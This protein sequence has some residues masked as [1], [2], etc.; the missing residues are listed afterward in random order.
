MNTPVMWPNTEACTRFFSRSLSKISWRILGH[1]VTRWASSTSATSG[2]DAN[3]VP[4][5]MRDSPFFSR[6]MTPGFCCPSRS[7]LKGIS[8]NGTDEGSTRLEGAK[9]IQDREQRGARSQT[10]EK[11]RKRGR[12]KQTRRQ[13]HTYSLGTVKEEEVKEALNAAETNL[14]RFLTCR[15][16][17]S[18]A[19]TL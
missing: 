7:S 1:P 12:Q 19:M 15:F 17:S 11:N 2:S 6:A 9:R 14:A 16:P 13:I 8:S 5:N 10:G 4:V 3:L 18:F